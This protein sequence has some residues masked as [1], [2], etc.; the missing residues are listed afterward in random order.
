MTLEQSCIAHKAICLHANYHT[1]ERELKPINNAYIYSLHN[2]RVFTYLKGRM[3]LS[4]GKGARLSK[5]KYAVFFQTSVGAT[6]ANIS[7]AKTSHIVE[8]RVRMREI[9]EVLSADWG[10]PG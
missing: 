4:E 1:Q 6:F 9:Y 5:A 3:L 8:L 7:L 10:M 2:T